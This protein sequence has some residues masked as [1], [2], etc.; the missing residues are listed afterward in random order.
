M[1]KVQIFKSLRH[2]LFSLFSRNFFITARNFIKGRQSQVPFCAS[3]SKI[4]HEPLKWCSSWLTHWVL[5]LWSSKC[6][7][8]PINHIK[9]IQGSVADMGLNFGV[10]VVESNPHRIVW[11]PTEMSAKRWECYFC[12]KTWL[13][14][15]YFSFCP[16][17][18]T[19]IILLKGSTVQLLDNMII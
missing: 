9:H 4:F 19:I 8:Q 13:S 7:P 2:H 12:F 18:N 1:T 17:R 5:N 14:P 6:P 11:A 10:V 16:N 15:I 3:V